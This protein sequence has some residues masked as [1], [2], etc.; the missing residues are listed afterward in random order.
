MLSILLALLWSSVSQCLEV[1][2]AVHTI[3]NL[4]KFWG[5]LV[6]LVDLIDMGDFV[7]FNN[8]LVVKDL[9]FHFIQNFPQ[10]LN[11]SWPLFL[12]FRSHAN[13]TVDMEV[14]FLLNL[15]N[16]L[17]HFNHFLTKLF[18]FTGVLRVFCPQ[19]IDCYPQSLNL[20]FELCDLL[21]A[22]SSKL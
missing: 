1:L 18:F 21:V 10:I 4:A 7:F 11:V 19:S 13:V 8:E 6:H 2:F 17:R 14:P 3:N 9:F 12:A 22:D 16:S 15:W 5:P 20:W